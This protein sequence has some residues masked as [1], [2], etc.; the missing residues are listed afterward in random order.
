M[1]R[2]EMIALLMRNAEIVID[3]YV[4]DATS[5]EKARLLKKERARLEEKT[6]KE[7]ANM[8]VINCG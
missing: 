5:D 6:D 4:Y 7:L 3:N 2:S 8:V 1:E